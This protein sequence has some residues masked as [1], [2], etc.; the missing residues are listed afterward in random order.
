[1]KKIFLLAVLL[2]GFS[3]GI[4]FGQSTTGTA[5]LNI[6][7]S[8]V[9]SM[10]VTQPP[11]LTVNFDDETKYTSGITA[12][13]DDH[14]TVISSKG[15]TVKAISGAIT[16]PSALTAASVKLT[17]AI[18]GTNGGNTGGTF[19]YASDVALPAVATTAVSVISSTATSWNG[20][21]SANKFK[22]T[23]LI[24]ADGQFAGKTT[25][26]NVIPVI[27]TVTQP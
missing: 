16:G 22:M 4:S 23:Y 10:T 26:A 18:G 12:V 11:A 27:Y 19:T 8:D 9:L 17:A 6:T 5:N 7:L 13:A 21:V 2:A 1:M 3:A 20:A 24:G 25:G 15:Y 14:I